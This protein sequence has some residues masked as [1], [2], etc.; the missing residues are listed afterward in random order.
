M[1]L[2]LLKLFVFKVL[3]GVNYCCINHHDIQLING[4]GT[5]KLPFVPGSELAGEVL[6]VGNKCSRKPGDKVLSLLCKFVVF[7]S[8]RKN[9]VIVNHFY[10]NSI[11]NIRWWFSQRMYCKWL[12]M[13][14]TWFEIATRCCPSSSKLWQCLACI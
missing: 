2:Y 10:I 1:I 6:E 13:L 5:P 9:L 8:S 11:K 3:V 7:I 4:H 14:P 12:W